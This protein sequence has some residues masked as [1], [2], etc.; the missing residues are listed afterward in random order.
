MPQAL[1]PCFTAIEKKRRERPLSQVIVPLSNQYDAHVHMRAA[2]FRINHLAPV[3]ARAVQA[4][5]SLAHNIIK[6]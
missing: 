3:R 4:K 2:G 6:L 5:Y 1:L